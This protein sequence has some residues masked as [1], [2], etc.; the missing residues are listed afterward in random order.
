MHEVALR[1]EEPQDIVRWLEGI[2]PREAE[3]LFRNAGEADRQAI[4]AQVRN[5]DDRLLGVMLEDPSVW[6][7]LTAEGRLPPGQRPLV[8]DWLLDELEPKR[9]Q[10]VVR[11]RCRSA[12]QGLRAL[13]KSRYPLSGPQRTRVRR[14][15]TKGNPMAAGYIALELRHESRRILPESQGLVEAAMTRA[16]GNSRN[17]LALATDYLEWV[18]LPT[19]VVELIA[20][21]WSWDLRVAEGAVSHPCATTVAW[22]YALLRHHRSSWLNRSLWSEVFRRGYRSADARRLIWALEH[23]PTQLVPEV[24]DVASLCEW[25]SVVTPED[26]R[27]GL[28][29]L[30]KRAPAVFMDLVEA[31]GVPASVGLQPDDYV[32]LFESDEVRER[33]IAAASLLVRPGRG[34]GV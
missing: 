12:A 34:S 33:A 9:G 31:G 10:R 16:L 23:V 17:G 22:Q 2:R 20:R 29:A 8:A 28:R 18:D 14:I 30:A 26:A 13:V 11:A 1:I 27:L 5:V 21:E 15:L 25:T 3:R 24:L 4:A 19:T 32:A 6:R 7:I